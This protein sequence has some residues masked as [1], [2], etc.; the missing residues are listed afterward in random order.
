MEL[1]LNGKIAIVC[2]ASR[3]LGYAVAQRLA[4]EH[5]RVA[6][7]A[8]ETAALELAAETL[9]KETGG[10]ILPL[11]A[12]VADDAQQHA[13]FTALSQRWGSPDIVI[14]NA[15]GPK[16][17]TFAAVNDDD[18]Q[19]AFSLNLM[20]AVR[21][22]RRALPVMKE[23]RQGAILFMT[24]LSVRQPLPN[25]MLSNSLRAAV[26]NLAKTLADEVAPQGIR[27]N[28]LAPGYFLTPRMEVVIRSQAQAKGLSFEEQLAAMQAQIPLGR[29]G[30]PKEFGDFAAYL[31]SE[32]ASYV[33]G[34]QF[35]V[36]GGF[37]RSI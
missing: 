33:T 1:G 17:G 9:R 26:T 29:I 36:D 23:R 6:I 10:E 20:S 14:A 35:I 7:V 30:D 31:V 34:Q 18:W 4:R 19:A 25:M 21:L 3:G 5:A 13:A 8:R 37:S 2:G 28:V 15:G 32:R 27:V 24:S 16:P 22:V 12:D 11:A